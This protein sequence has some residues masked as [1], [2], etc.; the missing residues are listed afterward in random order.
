VR[1]ESGGHRRN[2]FRALAQRVEVGAKELRIVGSNTE[3]LRTLVAPSSAKSGRHL[4]A[5]AY[6]EMARHG[7][8]R[9]A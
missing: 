4:A 9:W 7:R 5:I 6:S 3:Q 2:H 8:S 1:T